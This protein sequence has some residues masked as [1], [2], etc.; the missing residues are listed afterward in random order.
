M[1]AI[2]PPGGFPTDHSICRNVHRVADFLGR[3]PLPLPARTFAVSCRTI[4]G[5]C[6]ARPTLFSE[7]MGGPSCAPRSRIRDADL[8][9][10]GQ[11]KFFGNRLV[12]QFFSATPSGQA[13]RS[14]FFVP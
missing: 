10:R 12:L 14:P 13:R 3:V 5:R 6:L 2:D 11:K 9:G 7:S 8:Y 4:P 1:L